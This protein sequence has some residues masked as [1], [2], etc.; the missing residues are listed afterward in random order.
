MATTNPTPNLP[1]T[2]RARILPGWMAHD[3]AISCLTRECVPP[4]AV[5]D[6]EQIW[7]QYRQRVE[8]LPDNRILSP[9]YLPMN[10]QESSHASDFMQFLNTRGPHQV[11]RVVK[12]EL[13]QLVV[14]QYCVITERAEDY[15]D[16][17]TS[18]AEWLREFLPITVPQVQTRTSFSLGP[19]TS[20]HP[21]SSYIEID[22]PHGEFALLPANPALTVFGA[23]QFMRHVTGCETQN[24]LLLKAGYH[25]AYARILSA[26]T[27]TVPTALIALELNTCVPPANQLPA[28]P[29]ETEGTADFN[30]FGRRA[31]LFL[32]FF[33]E[34]FFMD[35]LLKRKRYQ[36][37]IR[38][39]WLALDV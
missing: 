12:T 3:E 7:R 21:L 9:Q 1:N 33:T 19:P 30:P 22:I 25:R 15:H 28:V 11:S 37:Q 24:R 8:A 16:R 2:V 6:A 39:T 18:A 31:A 36:L 35:V 32:D 5:Q 34:G 17:I 29:G 27:A 20:P 23:A 14:T 4:M 10:A 26:P 38:S 13:R